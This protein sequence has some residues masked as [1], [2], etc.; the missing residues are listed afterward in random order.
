MY[1]IDFEKITHTYRVNN[2]II[3]S[4]TQILESEGL[5]QYF[6]K[7]PWYMFRGEIIHECTAMIDRDTLNWDSVDD[8]ILGYLSA[9]KS[10]REQS[11]WV[12]EHIE[13]P[14]YHPIYGYCGTPDRFNNDGVLL[15]VKCGEGFPL[16]LT[17]Y[18]ELLKANDYKLNREAYMLNLGENGKYSL[19]PY[20]FNK[21]DRG[22]FLCAVTLNNWKRRME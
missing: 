11:E 16:Q 8:R 21:T 17:G 4:V 12:F 6:N 5:S 9:Y 14:L 15:D 13:K 1:E 10:F 18:G 3:S 22:V 19:K 2:E 7:D 20:K